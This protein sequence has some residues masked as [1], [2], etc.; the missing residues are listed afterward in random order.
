M[1]A[2]QAWVS[3][4]AWPAEVKLVLVLGVAFPILFLSYQLFVRH[5]FIGAVL[6]GRRAPRRAA[7]QPETA[8]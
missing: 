6:N 8:A 5:T 2:L 7:A 4:L 1:L 3:Q